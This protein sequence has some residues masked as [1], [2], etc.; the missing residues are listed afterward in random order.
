VPEEAEAGV[1]F[2][3]QSSVSHLKISPS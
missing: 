1:A 3:S 2:L